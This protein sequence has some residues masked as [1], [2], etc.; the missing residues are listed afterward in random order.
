MFSPGRLGQ[1]RIKQG[2]VPPTCTGSPCMDS[3]YILCIYRLRW[4]RDERFFFLK[5]SQVKDTSIY[6]Q[7]RIYLLGWVPFKSSITNRSKKSFFFWAC[8]VIKNLL[9]F[10]HFFS[11]FLE[12]DFKGQIGLP[13]RIINNIGIGCQSSS[14]HYNV[15]IKLKISYWK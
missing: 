5:Y 4:F 7:S 8:V 13:T 3:Y 10:Y 14:S 11:N 12:N 6:I 1:T 15:C 2:W 9:L